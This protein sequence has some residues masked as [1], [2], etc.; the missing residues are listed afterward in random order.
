LRGGEEGR[1]AGGLIK[2]MEGAKSTWKCQSKGGDWLDFLRERE[3]ERELVR[4][5]LKESGGT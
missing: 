1:R 3:R 2:E 4:K 5:V